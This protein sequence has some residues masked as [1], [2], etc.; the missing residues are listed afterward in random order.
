MIRIMKRAAV[1]A[2]CFAFLSACIPQVTPP[3]TDM[4]A[5]PASPTREA[6][7]GTTWTIEQI[8]GVRAIS[9]KAA[10]RFEAERLGL[11]AGCN[12]MGGTWRLDGGRLAGGPYASTM[13]YCDGLMEQERALSALLEAQP[14]VTLDGDM[15][16]LRSDGHSLVA[17][18]MP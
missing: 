1:T 2:T 13:M 10:V 5:A 3:A 18:R 14:A 16:T 11:T 9:G 12:G 17:R 8:D 7:I 6:L 15:L 4:S